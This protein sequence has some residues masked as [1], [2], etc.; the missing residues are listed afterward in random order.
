MC[1][2]LSYSCVGLSEG[3]LDCFYF[4]YSPAAC[5]CGPDDRLLPRALP[6]Y[7]RSHPTIVWLIA[8]GTS[9]GDV[10]SQPGVRFRGIMFNCT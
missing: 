8:F 3:R 2:V 5:A 6:I 1:L 4:I 10:Y 7:L 9:L